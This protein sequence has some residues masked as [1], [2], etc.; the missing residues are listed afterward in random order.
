[1]KML[2]NNKE[3]LE[4]S[5]SYDAVSF[6]I[7][8][9]KMDV[10]VKNTHD[11]MN[12]SNKAY[13]TKY[14]TIMINYFFEK[15]YIHV[16]QRSAEKYRIP[17]FLY[18]RML[19]LISST[20]E[21]V[22]ISGASIIHK[23]VDKGAALLT[24]QYT[25]VRIDNGDIKDHDYGNA[26]ELGF[27]FGETSPTVFV[28]FYKENIVILDKN[29]IV[30]T[31]NELPISTRSG[32]LLDE[33][34]ILSAN[35]TYVFPT[36]GKM[37]STALLNKL[38]ITST[39]GMLQSDT[40]SVAP[41]DLSI[42]KVKSSRM[43]ENLKTLF[44][45]KVTI[46]MHIVGFRTKKNVTYYEPIHTAVIEVRSRIS[47]DLIDIVYIIDNYVFF[48]TSFNTSRYDNILK[49]ETVDGLPVYVGDIA[50]DQYNDAFYYTIYDKDLSNLY[51]QKYGYIQFRLTWMFANM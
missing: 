23:L 37:N 26:V 20:S 24:V 35:T 14:M 31:E 48:E 30:I 29:R 12:I 21:S 41:I 15:G 16:G 9:M 22:A 19:S 44:E 38:N 18:W 8:E 6:K 17:I 43:L 4:V 10:S 3:Y 1:M 46:K 47:G 32:G 45:N 33:S 25:P 13:F 28:L 40:L 11:E 27:S 34:L 49:D 36:T 50:Y 5:H 2:V 39:T 51:I 42:L 7:E